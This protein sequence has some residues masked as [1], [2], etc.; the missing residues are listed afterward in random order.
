[1][2]ETKG[3]L[4]SSYLS[5]AMDPMQLPR[6]VRE[7]KKGI[8]DSPRTPRRKTHHACPSQTRA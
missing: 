4:R 3:P 7:L 5:D 8:L 6:I 1:M 2:M